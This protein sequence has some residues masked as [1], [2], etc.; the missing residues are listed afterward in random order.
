MHINSAI[1]KTWSIDMC[2]SDVHAVS[3]IV[4]KT[5][6]QIYPDCSWCDFTSTA[7]NWIMLSRQ[8]P[9]V[10]CEGLISWSGGYALAKVPLSCSQGPRNTISA[11]PAA[12]CI[13]DGEF[14]AVRMTTFMHYRG[15][16]W[17]WKVFHRTIAIPIFLFH[18]VA[19][20]NVPSN[21]HMEIPPVP[22]LYLPI[23]CCICAVWE[24]KG[25][26]PLIS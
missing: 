21:L 14:E 4:G 22:Q 13:E 8:N 7:R 16:T 1:E 26:C 10:L 23:L 2:K 18:T 17:K 11:Y 15:R 3:N 20:Q 19:P 12:C 5:L 25:S 24:G 6:P 9:P